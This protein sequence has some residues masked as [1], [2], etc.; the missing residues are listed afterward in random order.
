MKKFFGSVQR[1]CLFC[2]SFLMIM[3]VSPAVPALEIPISP[4]AAALAPV[5]FTADYQPVLNQNGS[6]K[7]FKWTITLTSDGKKFS[8]LQPT[9]TAAALPGAGIGKP[10]STAQ[11]VPSALNTYGFTLKPTNAL[12]TIRYQF[13]TPVTAVQSTYALD[14]FLQ[15]GN[16][17]AQNGQNAVPD[18]LAQRVIV[19]PKRDDQ[20]AFPEFDP[21]QPI[22]TPV[23]E[24]DRTITGK[25]LNENEI[26]WTIVEINQDLDRLDQNTGRVV[27]ANQTLPRVLPQVD[28]SQTISADEVKRYSLNRVGTNGVNTNSAGTH[29]LVNDGTKMPP[30]SLSIRTVRTKITDSTVHHALGSASLESLK[31]DIVLYRFWGAVPEKTRAGMNVSLT[32]PANAGK[33]YKTSIAAEAESAVLKNVDRFQQSNG[34]FQRIEYRVSGEAPAG[35]RVTNYTYDGLA[36][37]AW[38]SLT[39]D[40]PIVPS[41]PGKYG[42]T[43]VQPIHFDYFEKEN[44]KGTVAGFDSKLDLTWKIPAR[45]EVGEQFRFTVPADIA[46]NYSPSTTVPF[47]FIYDT[48]YPNNESKALMQVYLVNPKQ[49]IFAATENAYSE[50]D[51]TGTFTIGEKMPVKGCNGAS[52]GVVQVNKLNDNGKPQFKPDCNTPDLWGGITPNPTQ[53]V[54]GDSH[55]VGKQVVYKNE[56]LGDGTKAPIANNMHNLVEIDWNMDPYRA[57][58]A[59][60]NKDIYKEDNTD[61]SITWDIIVNAGGKGE[62]KREL[63]LRDSFLRTLAETDTRRQILGILLVMIGQNQW[64]FMLLKDTRMVHIILIL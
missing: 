15:L 44:D 54:N 42:I 33:T 7:E 53:L 40:T 16:Y 59:I 41:A 36:S 4:T 21:N 2:I 1:A 28:T 48:K 27:E 62:F 25:Y 38:L 6:L 45:M 11:S 3:T 22:L 31:G 60:L 9:F 51:I 12:N 52:S 61:R 32:D 17:R 29:T 14:L 30:G 5:K 39:K 18:T 20:S 19:K 35:T 37:T 58:Y 63:W 46:I 13:T 10:V 57:S 50:T 26:E 47:S 49:L 64:K 56:W 55:Y 43:A 23:V 24:T 34:N 8:E